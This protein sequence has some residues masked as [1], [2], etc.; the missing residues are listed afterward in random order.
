MKPQTEEKKV[1]FTKIKLVA[2]FYLMGLYKD[3]YTYLS[4]VSSYY[5]DEAT[6]KQ[7]KYQIP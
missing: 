2:D 5:Q 3:C 6:L 4:D 1:D 7:N